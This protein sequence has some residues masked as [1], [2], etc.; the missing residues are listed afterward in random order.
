MISALD[1]A[2]AILT[3]PEHALDM[4]LSWLSP[5]RG[6]ADTVRGLCA[7]LAE[8][9]GGEQLAYKVG[10]SLINPSYPSAV[11][12]SASSIVY[13]LGDAENANRGFR[14]A[15]SLDT[16]N[17]GAAYGLLVV[18]LD[19][20]LSDEVPLLVQRLSDR[21]EVPRAF[22]FC[23]AQHLLD[24]G[25]VGAATNAFDN[26]LETGSQASPYEVAVHHVLEWRLGRAKYLPE[27]TSMLGPYLKSSVDYIK[28]VGRSVK[29][30]G[31]RGAML[32]FAAHASSSPGL[33]L[34][35]GVWRGN[36]IRVIAANVAPNEVHGFDC[37][38]GLPE[39]WGAI[40]KGS[41]SAHGSLP[42]V[43]PNVILHVGLFDVTLPVFLSKGDEMVRLLHIDCDTEASTSGVLRLLNSRLVPGSVILFDELLMHE[44][45]EDS[46]YK[47]LCSWASDSRRS[48]EVVGLS[49][50]TGQVA[51]RI[52]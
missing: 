31:S 8:Y 42:D 22:F 46:E 7:A 20:G 36:S 28:G 2:A 23:L 18:A 52:L 15:L 6:L 16:E 24:I 51:I 33:N 26:Y 11:I 25:N 41:Y 13:Q 39:A 43:P 29:I 9:D 30:I 50:F 48:Y 45:W 1:A 5:D 3:G 4:V 14:L 49:P 12:S 47:A 40:P 37:F 19:L 10:L 34:E 27:A 17:R 32:R 21:P 44:L 35:F 38:E